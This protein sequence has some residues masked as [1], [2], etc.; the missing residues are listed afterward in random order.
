MS[1]EPATLRATR[2]GFTTS[3]VFPFVHDFGS[4]L[5]FT[6]TNFGLS[7]IDTKDN[8]YADINAPDNQNGN[9]PLSDF[10]TLYP[11]HPRPFVP[12]TTTFPASK[13]STYYTDTGTVPIGPDD[14]SSDN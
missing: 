4:V 1:P 8:G 2:C 5:F 7:N 9:I 6:E 12:I 11:S 10:F 3:E 13:F 14:D